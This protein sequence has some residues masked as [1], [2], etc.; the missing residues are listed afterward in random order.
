MRNT[1]IN[2]DGVCIKI[3]AVNAFRSLY[4][5]LVSAHNYPAYTVVL[6][7]V[8]GNYEAEKKS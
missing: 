5:I 7:E 1:L 6:G 8:L 4:S 2:V 3:Y